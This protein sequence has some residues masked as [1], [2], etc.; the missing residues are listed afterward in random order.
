MGC[1]SSGDG[2]LGNDSPFFEINHLQVTLTSDDI[3]H[4]DIQSRSRW[5]E[6]GAAGI[7]T[8]HLDAAHQFAGLCINDLYR[9]IGIPCPCDD[10][11]IVQM[12]AWIVSPVIRCPFCSTTAARQFDRFSHLVSS[13]ANGYNCVVSKVRPDFIRV[14]DIERLSR[15]PTEAL[16]F[17][18]HF[19][20]A[21]VN[22]DKTFVRLACN[23]QALPFG[24]HRY[25][26]HVAFRRQ[27]DG[28]NQSQ[29]SRHRHHG[30]QRRRCRGRGLLALHHRNQD[31]TQSRDNRQVGFHFA[32][33]K[34]FRFSSVW[35]QNRITRCL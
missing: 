13:P 22:S 27:R 20:C 17:V 8:I 16:R 23:K 26:V 24:V 19:A 4:C 3:S 21:Q 9:T 35:K 32:S 18:D 14:R 25:V 15:I 11:R 1:G 10:G 33:P 12:A 30:H 7:G 28:L 5:L 6:R 29:K 2:P 31:Q 34:N